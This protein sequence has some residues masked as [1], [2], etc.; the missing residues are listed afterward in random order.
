[1]IFS[2][3]AENLSEA[4]ISKNS[5]LTGP[6]KI[7]ASSGIATIILPSIL[8]NI[9]FEIKGLQLEL[10]S[11]DSVSMDSKQDADIAIQT[12]RPSRKDLIASKLRRNKLW[13]FMHRLKYLEK[14]GVPQSIQDL[15][16]HCLIGTIPENF[17]TK[18]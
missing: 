10:V 1:M 5:K 2:K 13:G 14:N 12:Y 9:N 6:I 8:A 11:A 3:T 4:V 15:E 18:R 16:N 17:K 7:V